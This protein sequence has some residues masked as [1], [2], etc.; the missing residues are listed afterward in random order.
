MEEMDADHDVL[1][2]IEEKDGSCG[3]PFLFSISFGYSPDWSVLS[4]S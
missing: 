2:W 1:I 3:P 4:I